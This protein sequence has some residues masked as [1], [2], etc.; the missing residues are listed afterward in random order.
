MNPFTPP[1]DAARGDAA[2]HADEAGRLGLS[3]LMDGDAGAAEPVCLAWRDDA[4]LRARWHA[5][6]L[7][8]DVL[9]SEELATPAAHDARLLAAVRARLAR[10]PV[11]VAPQPAPARRGGWRMPAALAAGVAALAG[12]LVVLQAPD[13]VAPGGPG[14][15]VQLADVQAGAPPTVLARSPATPMDRARTLATAGAGMLQFSTPTRAQMLR[16]ARVDEY[17]RA[18]RDL[19]A[20]SPAALP[21][22]AMRSVDF[23]LP[24]R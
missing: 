22:G 21:G 7:I 9:R 5:Y 16:E 18:H 6:H 14:A 17:L 12:V 13:A 15:A 24:Q 4:A 23:Q 3:A 19:L 2:G 8:G 11:I 20:G 10:E 1:D